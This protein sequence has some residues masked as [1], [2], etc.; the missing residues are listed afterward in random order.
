MTVWCPATGTSAEVLDYYRQLVARLGLGLDESGSNLGLHHFVAGL[1]H[2]P[3]RL[4]VLPVGLDPR[5]IPLTDPTPYFPWTMIWRR[6][7]RGDELAAFREALTQAAAPD[8]PPAWDPAT[9]WLPP[10]DLAEIHPTG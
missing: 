4:L 6:G 2:R 9:C 1:D 10:A 3:D 5:S 8:G 7:N